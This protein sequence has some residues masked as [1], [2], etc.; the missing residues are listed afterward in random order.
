MAL[1][2]IVH[3]RNGPTLYKSTSGEN[4]A[5]IL[6]IAQVIEKWAVLRTELDFL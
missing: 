1:L 5:A 6:Y 4:C 3:S 2:Y